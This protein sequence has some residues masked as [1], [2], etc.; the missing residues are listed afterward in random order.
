MT[1][2]NIF[3]NWTTL[4]EGGGVKIVGTRPDTCYD[5]GHHIYQLNDFG[6]RGGV[7]IRGTRPDTWYWQ[8]YLLFNDF[9]RGRWEGK[10]RG[11]RPDIWYWQPF[12]W[13]LIW[14][15]QLYLSIQWMTLKV[16]K[17]ESEWMKWSPIMTYCGLFLCLSFQIYVISNGDFYQVYVI[18]NGDFIPT[19]SSC[20]W[21]L[22]GG[23]FKKANRFEWG[24]ACGKDI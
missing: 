21:M 4:G 2:A 19:T 23:C 5:I 11:T 13:D 12:Y 6:R 15:W 9:R 1:L 24:G 22:S 8:P 7:K 16:I 17:S 20:D 10:I 14:Y 3:I 18:P